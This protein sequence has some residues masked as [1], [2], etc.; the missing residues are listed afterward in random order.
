MG[1]HRRIARRS[2]GSKSGYRRAQHLTMQAI[3][4]ES[5]EG[6]LLAVKR[7]LSSFPSAISAK[8]SNKVRPRPC[9]REV[10]PTIIPLDVAARH[11]SCCLPWELT[12]DPTGPRTAFHNLA[13]TMHAAKLSHTHVHLPGTHRSG[14]PYTWPLR[15]AMRRWCASCCCRCEGKGRACLILLQVRGDK[16]PL[17]SPLRTLCNPTG[18]C[19][20]RA[21]CE[22]NPTT[23]HTSQPTPCSTTGCAMCCTRS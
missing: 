15:R 5:S 22:T 8:S 17:I 20:F 10:N 2:R 7:I 14:R 12:L 19:R 11:G 16:G 3:F 23:T 21:R 13:L 6:H 9:R 18:G 4:K 1:R